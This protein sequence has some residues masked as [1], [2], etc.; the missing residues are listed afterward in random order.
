M[1]LGSTLHK[2]QIFR[3]DVG[4]CDLCLDV[5][6]LLE[7]LKILNKLFIILDSYIHILVQACFQY[8]PCGTYGLLLEEVSVRVLQ[9]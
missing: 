8:G 5:I 2:G 9:V 4:V 1:N 6:S 7:D 3:R